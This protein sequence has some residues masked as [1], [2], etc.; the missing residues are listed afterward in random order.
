M[1][2]WKSSE[3]YVCI[4]I[5][6]GSSLNANFPAGE[7]FC[8]KKNISTYFE[9][10]L[11]ISKQLYTEQKISFFYQKSKVFWSHFRFEFIDFFYIIF[12]GKS[13]TGFVFSSFFFLQHCYK[14]SVTR[15]VYKTRFCR[16]S[17][18]TTQATHYRFPFLM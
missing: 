7:S 6:N 8:S 12:K 10:S 15:T 1:N 14:T 13:L 3:V 16:F 11:F 18:F 17:Y 9:C 2:L 5:D 4:N